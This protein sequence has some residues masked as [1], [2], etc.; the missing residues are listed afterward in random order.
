M[1]KG[2]FKG[3]TEV[4]CDVLGCTPGV[5]GVSRMCVVFVLFQQH[6]LRSVVGCELKRVDY[7]MGAQYILPS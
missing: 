5:E 7:S 4:M 1:Y 6:G 2:V 3:G